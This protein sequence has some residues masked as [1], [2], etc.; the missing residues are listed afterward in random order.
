MP[1]WLWI[2]ICLALGFLI[3]VLLDGNKEMQRLGGW[4]FVVG[5]FLLILVADFMS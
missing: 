1:M 3:I 5:S 2:V 4:V